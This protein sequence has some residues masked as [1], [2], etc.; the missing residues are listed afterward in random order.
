VNPGSVGQPRDHNPK[1]AYI[2]YDDE[3]E[4]WVYQRV[5]YDIELVQK[6]ILEA[7]LPHRHASRLL[8]GW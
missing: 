5:G 4:E 6:Q 1:A 2:L 7:G 3:T 8:E